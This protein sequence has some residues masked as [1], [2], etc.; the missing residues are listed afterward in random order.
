MEKMKQMQMEMDLLKRQIRDPKP[1]IFRDKLSRPEEKRDKVARPACRDFYRIATCCG[2]L[3]DYGFV[4]KTEKDA[5][6]FLSFETTPGHIRINGEDDDDRFFTPNH[7]SVKFVKL[8]IKH[9]M[10]NPDNHN[11]W[12]SSRRYYVH[13]GNHVW[14][15]INSTE[16]FAEI[17]AKIWRYYRITLCKFLHV[18]GCNQEILDMLYTILRGSKLYYSNEMVEQLLEEFKPLLSKPF[19]HR[20]SCSKRFKVI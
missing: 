2:T 16:F 9:L 10:S 15:Q 8:A 17:K 4:P 18:N 14:F 19:S 13:S 1:E 5:Q 11:F 6:K 3:L 12:L 20:I 7:L